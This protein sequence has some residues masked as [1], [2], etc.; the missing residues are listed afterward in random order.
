MWCNWLNGAKMAKKKEVT[1]VSVTF[2][3]T[4][5]EDLERIAQSKKV[6]L[7]WVVRDA[8]EKYLVEKY[9]LFQTRQ[10]EK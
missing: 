6:S 10:N 7:A 3:P 5:Y 2:P 1:R 8:A 4:V 9:P